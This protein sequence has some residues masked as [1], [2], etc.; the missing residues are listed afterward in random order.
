MKNLL[1]SKKGFQITEV[2]SLIIVLIVITIVLGIGASILSN[3]QQTST[4]S[5]LATA[6]YENSSFV[7]L[8]G[9]EVD[10]TPSDIVLDS[11][12]KVHLVSGSC[13]GVIL[14]NESHMDHT[15]EFTVT[16]CSALL[17]NTTRNNTNYKA[18]FTYTYN[19]YYIAYNITQQGMDAQYSLSSWQGTWVIIIAAAIVLG[20]LGK[21]FFF[22]GGT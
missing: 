20:I 19:E 3:V 7:A 15:T 9:T 17:S 22:K 5:G 21:Y 10:F 12:G 1:N 11:G 13:T 4:Y 16:G 18:N 14:V 6:F 2:P 8:N